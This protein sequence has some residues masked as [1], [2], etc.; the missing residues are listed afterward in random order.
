MLSVKMVFHLTLISSKRYQ[1]WSQLPGSNTLLYSYY[2]D[3][4]AAWAACGLSGDLG[5]AGAKIEKQIL[6]LKTTATFESWDNFT[7]VV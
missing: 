4:R 2:P 5:N 3:V 1:T 7:K 6:I